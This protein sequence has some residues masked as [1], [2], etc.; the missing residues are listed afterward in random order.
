[1]R[2]RGGGAIVNTASV[3]ALQAGAAPIAYSAAK[4]GV[5]HLSK[6]AAAELARDRIRVNAICPGLILTSIFSSALGL[7]ADA[8]AQVD[9]AMASFAPQVQPLPM[10]GR[11]EEVAKVALFLASD[12]SAFVTGTHV[13]VD[14]GLTIGPR[15][16]WDPSVPGP[17]EAL[18]GAA[19]AA[20]GAS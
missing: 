14:G 10:P 4:A 6:V 19:S 3:A 11:P 12:L 7:D 13:V 9:K 16:S 2:A 20:S 8:A 17:I 15:S 5:L 18:V 1:M